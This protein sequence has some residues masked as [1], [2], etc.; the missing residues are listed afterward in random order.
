MTGTCATCL[1]WAGNKHLASAKCRHSLSL[2]QT[3]KDETCR[4]YQQDMARCTTCGAHAVAG[5]ACGSCG[6]PV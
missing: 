3:A 5:G 1:H 2:R 6:A 4:H